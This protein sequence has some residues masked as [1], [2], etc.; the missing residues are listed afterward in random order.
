MCI[1]ITSLKV[2]H[3]QYDVAVW[4]R[5]YRPKR[6][7]D[8]IGNEE[9]KKTVRAWAEAWNSGR[10]QKPLLLYGPPGVGKTATAWA[11]ANEFGWDIIEM[12]ASDTR[13]R[14]TVKKVLGAASQA[15]SL[16]GR[17]KLILIDEV[18]GLSSREDAGGVRAIMEI[19]EKSK[20]PI[21]L[22]AND[23]WASSVVPLHKYVRMVEYKRV[24]TNQLAT[25]LMKILEK[26]GIEY[27]RD[28]ILYLAR[29][30]NG[31]VRSALLDLQAV[32][33]KGVK[34]T[35]DMVKDLGFRDREANIFE[36]LAKIFKSSHVVRPFA[37][38][39]TLDMD[40]DTFTLWVVENIPREYEDVT[41]IA[42]AFR[43]VSRSDVF[44]GRIIR[45]Q[46]WGFLAYSQELLVN[47]VIVAKKRHYRKFTRYSYP[48]WL[49]LLS[50][51]KERNHLRREVARK[52][53]KLFHISHR[54]VLLDIF[55]LL[56]LFFKKKEWAREIIKKA[57]LAEE[58]VALILGKEKVD[59]EV[60]EL[61]EAKL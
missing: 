7:A 35:I 42:E 16:F 50:K 28:A 61:F 6:L 5:K 48:T 38:T 44:A 22:T 33:K 43:W 45:R 32:A 21:I 56:P 13:D 36:V 40:P 41:E 18:D 4:T 49:R 27:D 60:K 29:K 9:A 51:Y 52:L 10:P 24:S 3:P 31:D 26:E 54:R 15:I 37:L 1:P 8:I 20:N 19:L 30:E 46:Y 59:E 57:R 25:Y 34:I 14:E 17:R 11:I 23:A 2:A 55:P 39:A 58:E 12:N 47:G 53:G